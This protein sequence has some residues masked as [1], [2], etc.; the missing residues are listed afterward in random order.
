MADTLNGKVWVV[1]PAAGIGSRMQS[2][3]PKQYLKIHDKTIIEYTMDCFISHPEVAGIVL[4]LASDDPYWKGVSSAQTYAT[5]PIYTVEGGSERSDSVLQTL[6]YLTMVEKLDADCWVMV[7]DAARPCLSKA[8]I[9]NLLSSRK[10]DSDGAI[11]ASP[12]RDTMKRAV[13]GNSTI[14]HTESRDNLWHALTPQMFKLG[15]LRDALLRC[16]EKQIEVT[17][18]ASAMEAMG[19]SIDLIEGDSSNIKITRPADIKLASLFLGSRVEAD[20]E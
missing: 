13:R 7:H 19:Y 5:T 12:V 20:S 16:R 10:K 18:D 11:L 9:D 3:T 1:M 2:D 14:S 4:A 17:D 6:D 15:V 8:D